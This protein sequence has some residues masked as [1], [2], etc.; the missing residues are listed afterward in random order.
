MELFSG[1]KSKRFEE[2][3]KSL[4]RSPIYRITIESIYRFFELQEDHAKAFVNYDFV[5]ENSYN[6]YFNW[7]RNK[8]YYKDDDKY[9]VLTN[10]NAKYLFYRFSD[11][12]DKNS[13]FL[14]S[15]RNGKIR[16]NQLALETIQNQNCQYFLGAL[17]SSSNDEN[18]MMLKYI[19]IIKLYQIHFK[20][21]KFVK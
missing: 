13:D 20:I 10:K 21:W 6:E 7:L 19:K 18:L 4:A 16:N 11:S 3:V 9:H 14:K 12:L 17:L 2:N 1:G 8:F 15:V 5:F